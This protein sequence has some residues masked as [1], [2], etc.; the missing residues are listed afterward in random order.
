MTEIFAEKKS[1]VPAEHFSQN[2]FIIGRFNHLSFEN[3]FPTSEILVVKGEKKK[4]VM[5]TW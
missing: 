3:H 1:G 4:H 5:S 2:S